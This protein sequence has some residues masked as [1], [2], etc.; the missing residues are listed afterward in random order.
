MLVKRAPVVPLV[1]T[2]APTDPDNTDTCSA[3]KSNGHPDEC[4]IPRL[5]YWNFTDHG[6]DHTR[7]YVNLKRWPTDKYVIALTIRRATCKPLITSTISDNST[8]ILFS[9]S[10]EKR[11]FLTLKIKRLTRL[12]VYPHEEIITMFEKRKRINKLNHNLPCKVCKVHLP[13]C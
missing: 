6:V 3:A 9:R 12:Q 1:I 7:Y 2:D 10:N 11:D 5:K 8:V 4:V 13:T